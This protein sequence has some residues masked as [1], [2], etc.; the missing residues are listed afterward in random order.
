MK[1]KALKSFAGNGFSFHGGEV[2]EISN[3]LGELLIKDGLV[4]VEPEGA[5]ATATVKT[6]AL[7][8]TS[9]K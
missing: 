8:K 2:K 4:V 3:E 1:V 5:S 6:T 9:K 7:K